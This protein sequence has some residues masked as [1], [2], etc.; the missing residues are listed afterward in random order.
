MHIQAPSYAYG[1][2]MTKTMHA[3]LSVGILASQRIRGCVPPR[4]YTVLERETYYSKER[5]VL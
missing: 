5:D 3:Y 1:A 2:Y 4:F